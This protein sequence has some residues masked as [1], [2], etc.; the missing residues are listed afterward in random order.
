MFNVYNILCVGYVCVHNIYD[1]LYVYITEFYYVDEIRRRSVD[2]S[3]NHRNSIF[4]C[5]YDTTITVRDSGIMRKKIQLLTYENLR[6]RLLNAIILIQPT[7][8]SRGGGKSFRRSYTSHSTCSH[9]RNINKNP[10]F[11]NY[12]LSEQKRPHSDQ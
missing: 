8:R 11:M 2:I 10:H 9:R 12:S 1:T 6:G 5:E 3:F 7:A 4:D